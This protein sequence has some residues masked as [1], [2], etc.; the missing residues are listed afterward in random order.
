F[1]AF[2]MIMLGVFH[3]IEGL[4]AIFNDGY[5]LV[6]K[7]GLIVHADYTAWGWTHLILGGVIAF[8]GVSLFAG[9]MSGRIVAVVGA[10]VRS[11]GDVGFLAAYPVWSAIM[12]TLDVLVIWAVIVHGREMR[13]I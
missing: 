7:S 12:I 6:G 3:A 10:L 9:R 1:A 11:V 5:Y 2:M 13:T 8:A 4:V